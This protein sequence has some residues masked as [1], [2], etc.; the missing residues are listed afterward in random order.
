MVLTMLRSVRCASCALIIAI[1]IP[2]VS[3][4]CS[5]D[6]D[7]VAAAGIE[8]LAIPAGNFTMGDAANKYEQN[9]RPARNVTVR[10]FMMSKT[11]ITQQQYRDVMGSNPSKAVGDNLP[12]ESLSWYE[13]LEFCNKLSEKEGRTPCY[14]GIP[15]NV[16][17][18]FTANGYRLP[19]EAEWEYA[20][21]AGTTTDYYVGNSTADL[22]RCSWS[23]GNSSGKPNEVAKLEANAWGLHDMHGNVFEWVWDWYKV[24]YY[25]EGITD[26]PTG[27]SGGQEKVCRG[28]SWFVYYYG[29]RVSFRS[30]LRP[31]FRSIDIG[32]RV[33]RKQG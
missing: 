31:S 25:G 11:E 4:S 8:M 13:A 24:D 17:C 21:R 20:C 29:H 3:I 1:I 18:D 19:T 16:T 23:S 26:N 27:P 30:M 28:G 33:V 32:L 7:P 9:E 2:L 12:V 5:E 14:S 6:E 22:N 15:N 10:A